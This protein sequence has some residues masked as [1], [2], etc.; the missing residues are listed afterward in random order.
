[1]FT[2]DPLVLSGFRASR[3]IWQGIPSIERSKG[4]RLFVSFYS[5]GTTEQL[6][7]Y[8]ALV[9][10]DD[11]GK[12]F[13]EPIAAAVPEDGHRCYDSCLWIDP[14]GRLWFWW[15]VMPDHAVWTV[16]C[17]DPDAEVLRWSEE[18]KIGCDV[19]MNKP[20]V[21]SAGDWLFPMAVWASSVAVLHEHR[22]LREETAPFVWRSSDEGKTFMKI[23]GPEIDNRSFDEHMILENDDGSLRMLVRTHDGI[24]EA[25]STDGGRTWTHGIKSELTGPDSRFHIKRLRSGRV[26]LVNHANFT[27]R[28]NLTAFLSE[29][30][31]K[32]WCASLLLDGRSGVSYPDCAS[33]NGDGFLYIV[34]DHERGGYKSC[35][36]DAKKEAREILYAKITEDD[37]LAGCLVN[38]GS[39]L[40][41]VATKLGEYDGD[42]DALYR[43]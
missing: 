31:G 32:T 7:N 8:C 20:I 33:E 36:A 12:T 14:K 18:R 27:G 3:R 23:G 24:A 13:S 9:I 6:G 19:M 10:S 26:L 38:P 40:A 5:G 16:T 2:N 30:G 15:A 21:T 39:R 41:C 37:I 35:F 43:K 4:G 22:S 1:M 11:D 42:A 25:R 28:N 17:D 29:D 34:Y